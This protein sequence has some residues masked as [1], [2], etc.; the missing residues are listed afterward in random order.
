MNILVQ[1]FSGLNELAIGSA[2]NWPNDIPKRPDAPKMSENKS[3]YGISQSL[4]KC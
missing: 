2:M 3:L 4:D 1:S